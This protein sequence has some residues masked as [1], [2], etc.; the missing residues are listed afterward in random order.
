L[1]RILYFTVILFFGTG[2]ISGMPPHTR[3]SDKIE[4]GETIVPEKLY[5]ENYEYLASAPRNGI[6]KA[7]VLLVDFPDNNAGVE[8]SFFEDLLN[9]E[10]LNFKEKYPVSTNHLSTKEY[11]NFVSE[12]QYQIS[13]DI[14]GWFE[15][16]QNYSYYCGSSNG[17]G[18]YPHNTQKMV[19]DLI[20]IADA[21]V[22]FSQYDNDGDGDV[23]FLLVV[24]AGTGAEFTGE[25]SAIWS[26]Q[27]SISTKYKDGKSISRY[28]TMPEFWLSDNDMTTGVYSHELGHL[29]FGLPDLYDTSKSSKGIGY[30]GLMGSGSWNDEMAVYGEEEESGYGGAPAEPVSWVK[31]TLG[32]VSPVDGNVETGTVRLEKNDILKF[33][34]PANSNQYFLLEY[35]DSSIL[36]SY[37]PGSSGLMISLI[38]EAKHSN[39]QPWYPGKPKTSHY[40][41]AVI[42]NDGLWDLEK[43]V[44]R[45]NAEDLYYTGDKFDSTS[46]PSNLF[47]DETEGINISL[48]LT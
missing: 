36:N 2:I 8:V 33:T 17:L 22:D 20:E 32:W 21:D 30:W 43:N 16:P 12:G 10:G 5:E 47:W 45:G 15:V 9:S 40:M 29:L 4:R 39:S 18:S 37:L 6:F 1:K 35:K 14:F 28:C 19:E 42:Q 31:K 41:V 34:N 3:I 23:D 25:G 11:Y 24:H 26:H 38:D 13:F 27:S 44:S 48:V 7:L 46:N